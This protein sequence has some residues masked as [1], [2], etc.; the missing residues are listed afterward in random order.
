M[1]Q[2]DKADAHAYR[3]LQAGRIL[4]IFEASTGHAAHSLE[5]LEQWFATPEA[6]AALAI[7]RDPETGKIDPS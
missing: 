4:E 2:D 6:Q 5:E 1:Q 7:N 3:L